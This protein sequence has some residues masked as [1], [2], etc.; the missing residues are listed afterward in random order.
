MSY[1]HP[2]CGACVSI[3]NWSNPYVQEGGRG[4]GRAENQTNPA[5]DALALSKTMP[6]VAAFYS[7]SSGHPFGS[8]DGVSR[9]PGGARV[10][11][12]GLDPDTLANVEVFVHVDAGG[13]SIG[14]TDFQRLDVRD[15]YPAYGENRGFNKIVS[16]ANGQHNVCVDLVNVAGTVGANQSLGCRLIVIG[17][18]PIGNADAIQRA[19]LLTVN[20]T[21]WA[22]D[23]DTASPITIRLTGTT[24]G[25]TYTAN[26]GRPQDI[27]QMYPDYGANHGFAETPLV[28][29]TKSLCIWAQNAPGTPGAETFLRCATV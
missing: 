6:T 2:D 19:N 28:I 16:M 1:R 24:S 25:T 11:G 20:V 5:F 18:N 29:G 12:W 8:F 14:A 17:N 3:L 22:I 26:R 27:G 23:P 21:G 15:R 10:S 9:A 7:T 13:T 4:T